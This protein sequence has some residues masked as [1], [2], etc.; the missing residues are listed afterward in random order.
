MV[1]HALAFATTNEAGTCSGAGPAAGEVRKRPT[2][3]SSQ[4]RAGKHECWEVAVDGQS[5]VV[6][7]PRARAVRQPAR[8]LGADTAAVLREFGATC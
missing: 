5:Q 3:G 8:P 2:E 1:A 4:Y 7:V 6:R